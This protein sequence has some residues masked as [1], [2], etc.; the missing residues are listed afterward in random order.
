MF[1]HVDIKGDQLPAGTLCLTYDDGP[2]ETTGADRGAG[3]RT[4]EL[5][6]YLFNEGISASF[7][8]IGDHAQRHPGVMSQL[9]RLK[10]TIGNHTFTHSGLVPL[11][12]SGGK[13][14]EEISRTSALIRSEVSQ[15]IMFFRAP[16]GNWRETVGADPVRDKPISI[17]ADLLNRHNAC[18]SLVGPINWDISGHDYDYWRKGLSAPECAAEYLESIERIGSGIVLLHDSSEDHLIRAGNRTCELTKLIVPVLKRRGY[19]FIGLDAIPQVRS[20]IRVQRQCAL[21]ASNKRFVALDEDGATLCARSG[22]IGNR[23]QF[24]VVQL[25]G[26]RIA[27]RTSSGSYLSVREFD[28]TH[29]ALAASI[30]DREV[31]RKVENDGNRF[32][33]QTVA[34][35]V[36]RFG[37]DDDRI[38]LGQTWPGVAALFSEINLFDVE[39]HVHSP[40]S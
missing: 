2:G 40:H 21:L 20:A 3:P 5:G 24:G 30:G 35:H 31:F 38:I 23:E 10:H 37:L 4:L 18:R 26:D 33:L 27:L 12:V 16:F 11:A 19:K 14:V 1:F 28:G 9:A 8:I 22:S 34:G 25:G 13:V 36:L 7:F 17:V 39:A 32:A 6:E 15:P 29:T